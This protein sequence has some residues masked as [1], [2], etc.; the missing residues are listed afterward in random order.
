MANP[1]PPV[2]DDGLFIPTTDVYD[3]GQIAE[4]EV[5]S[6][7]FKDLLV[8]LYQNLNVMATAVNWKDS[9]FYDTLEFVNGQVFYPN[10]ANA[11]S[12]VDL[13][14]VYRKVVNFG[15]LTAGAKTVNHGLPV[16]AAYTWT[17]I[18]AAATDPVALTGIPIPYASAVDVAHNIELSVD[19]TNVIITS[20]GNDY[21]NYTICN[22]V[23]EY[24]K[25]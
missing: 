1:I 20:G 13:R 25:T 14:P 24:L 19:S 12:Q 21:S 3:T 23:L 9:G 7:E 10:P 4:I 2:Q 17:R 15:A 16:N 11:V 22:V 6:P 5:N 18:Y 8:R